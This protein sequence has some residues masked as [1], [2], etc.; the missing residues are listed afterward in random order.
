MLDQHPGGNTT[1]DDV[2]GRFFALAGFG[3]L[4]GDM[5][6]YDRKNDGRCKQMGAVRQVLSLMRQYIPWRRMTG[7]STEITA[8]SV[9]PCGASQD[10]RNLLACGENGCHLAMLSIVIVSSSAFVNGSH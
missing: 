3:N 9:L 5:V 7:R 4:P 6:F 1:V 10:I 8:S 2:Q